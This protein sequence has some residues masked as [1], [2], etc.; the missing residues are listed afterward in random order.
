MMRNPGDRQ[1]NTEPKLNCALNFLLPWMKHH[2][3]DGGSFRFWFQITDFF[4]VRIDDHR[5]VE[6]SSGIYGINEIL[7]FRA[8]LRP[9]LAIRMQSFDHS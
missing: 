6:Y 8:S 7:H 1:G 3:V 4:Q 9:N 5:S 2:F